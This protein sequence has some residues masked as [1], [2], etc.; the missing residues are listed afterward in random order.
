MADKLKDFLSGDNSAPKKDVKTKDTKPLGRTIKLSNGNR[1]EAPK[2]ARYD[3]KNNQTFLIG[4]NN[5]KAHLKKKKDFKPVE[6]P[7][8]T[9]LVPGYLIPKDPFEGLS[10]KQ[11]EYKRN[12]IT[13]KDL[14]QRTPKK[15]ISNNRLGFRRYLFINELIACK[16][17]FLYYLIPLVLS[18]I[19]LILNVFNYAFIPNVVVSF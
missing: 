18:F 6:N 11:K 15:V 17:G 3:R 7:P 12:L 2:I 9:F 10:E 13:D 1:I 8:S 14:N 4:P 16:N 19:F 5:K